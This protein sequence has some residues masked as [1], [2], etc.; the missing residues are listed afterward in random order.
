M[1]DPPTNGKPFPEE[2]RLRML[3]HFSGDGAPHPDRWA[4]LWDAGDFLPWD[5]GTPHPA[6]V[7][8]MHDRG[9]L[10]G[11]SPLLEAETGGLRRKRAL[12]PGC[13]RGYDVLLLASC[14]Y[15]VLGLEVSATAV[16]SARAWVAE[17]AAEYPVRDE[18]VGRG[19]A[20]I[21][22]GDFWGDGWIQQVGG[23]ERF[24]LIYDYTVSRSCSVCRAEEMVVPM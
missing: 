17:R 5:Q 1:D 6:L 14:G 21:V 20:E 12:V 15:D 16:Q 19:R 7:D 13:G 2:S 18:A 3:K 8:L 24:E 4:A 22:L 11:A 10:V 23:L 9:D